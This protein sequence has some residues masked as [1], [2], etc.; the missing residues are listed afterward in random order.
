MAES[1]DTVTYELADVGT[2]FIA[3]LID[4]LILGVIGVLIGLVLSREAGSGIGFLIGVIYN[5]YFWTRKE[6]QTPGKQAMK[7]RVIK[8]DGSPISDGDAIL[9]YI[10]YYISGLILGLGYLWAIWDDNH[11]AWHDMIAKTYVVKA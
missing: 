10:G 5:W 11:Q 7:I 4:G 3:L 6:G 1:S 9:R 8:T 2:R